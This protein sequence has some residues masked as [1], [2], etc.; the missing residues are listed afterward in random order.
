MIIRHLAHLI[1]YMLIC[2]LEIFNIIIIIIIIIT[3]IINSRYLYVHL[4]MKTNM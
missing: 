4:T 3:I 1:I 2:T